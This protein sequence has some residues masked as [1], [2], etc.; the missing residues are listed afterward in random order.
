MKFKVRF[1]DNKGNDTVLKD[2]G[3]RDISEE[4]IIILWGRLPF[5]GE[6]FCDY[7]TTNEIFEYTRVD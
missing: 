1:G 7:T 6:T 2:G 5:V 4:N 3:F